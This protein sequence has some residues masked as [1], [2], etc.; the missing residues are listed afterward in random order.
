[1][2]HDAVDMS[3]DSLDRLRPDEWPTM[4]VT[5]SAMELADKPPLVRCSFSIP[6]EERKDNRTIPVIRPFCLWR[7]KVVKY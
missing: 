3:I 4:R 5:A 2:V 6:L 7:K 1:M